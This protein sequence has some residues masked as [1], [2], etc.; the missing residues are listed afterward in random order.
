[1]QANLQNALCGP[2]YSVLHTNSVPAHSVHA[3]SSTS[4]SNSG[5]SSNSSSAATRKQDLYQILK[6]LIRNIQLH[7]G[8]GGGKDM[9]QH[10]TG[11]NKQRQGRSRPLPMTQPVFKLHPMPC[12]AMPCHAVTCFTMLPG[13]LCLG[14]VS[15][16]LSLPPPFRF[17]IDY[18]AFSSPESAA[19]PEAALVAL[20][21]V[22]TG[23]CVCVQG[24]GVRAGR[25]VI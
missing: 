13:V 22:K 6:A 11:D 15:R 24:Q 3:S 2:Q 14:G 7:G 25:R 5:S 4:S 10:I 17:W 9:A 1:M 12:C 16:P 21:G 18:Q 8:H 19:L 23:V 20:G